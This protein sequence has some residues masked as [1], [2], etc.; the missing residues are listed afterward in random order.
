MALLFGTKLHVF[1]NFLNNP[2]TDKTAAK[3][4][5]LKLLIQGTKIHFQYL[6]VD[7]KR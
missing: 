3:F 7:L 2:G 5:E 6:T 4:I 1:T